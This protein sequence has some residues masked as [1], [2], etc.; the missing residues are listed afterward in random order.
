MW[1]VLQKSK[2]SAVYTYVSEIYYL[3]GRGKK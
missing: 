3:H 2:I 1:Y